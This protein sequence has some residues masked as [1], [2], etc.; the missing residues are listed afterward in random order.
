MAAQFTEL[1]RVMQTAIPLCRQGVPI[2]PTL[3]VDNSADP[4]RLIQRRRVVIN[5]RPSTCLN[6]KPY[7]CP[8]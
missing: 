5:R 7:G 8:E 6:G 4:Q 1:R 2:M 3:P